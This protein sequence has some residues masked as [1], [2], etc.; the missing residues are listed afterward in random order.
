[1]V[2][3]MRKKSVRISK[4]L[5]AMDGSEPSFRAAKYAIHLAKVERAKITL[6]HVLDNI[7]G[8]GAIALQA[9]YGNIRPSKALFKISEGAA[10]KWIEKVES[11]ATR[12][13]IRLTS[14]I[15]LDRSSKAEEIIKYA[16]KNHMD[17]IV[18]GT[19]GLSGFK[20]MALGS[21][22]NGVIKRAKRPALVAQ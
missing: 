2:R 10:R 20:R 9:R 15:R 7:R 6:L 21:V 12:N 18:M 22:A 5:L 4:I 13:G 3:S 17:L 16:E 8:G 1:M 14:E 19:R 11:E